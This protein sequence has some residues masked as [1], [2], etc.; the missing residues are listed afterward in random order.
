MRAV[1]TTLTLDPDVVATLREAQRRTGEPWKKVVNDALRLGAHIALRERPARV[2][3]YRT[4][5]VDPGAPAL[6]GVHSVYDLLAFAEG[7]DFR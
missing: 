6:Q 3:T 1:R 4:P 2:E 7:E 5:P